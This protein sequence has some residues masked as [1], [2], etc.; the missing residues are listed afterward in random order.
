MGFSGLG[1]TGAIKDSFFDFWLRE[2]WDSFNK[3]TECALHSSKGEMVY[4]YP[5]DEMI[6]FH[7]LDDGNIEI[8]DCYW[9]NSW[10]D[11]CD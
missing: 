7:R 8:T 5:T 11:W 1:D 9:V 10:D 6:V 4:Y 3:A 2:V